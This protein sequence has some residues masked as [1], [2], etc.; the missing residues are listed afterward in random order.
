MYLYCPVQRAFIMMPNSSATSP[1]CPKK[2]DLQKW[3]IDISEKEYWG[4]RGRG[5]YKESP[6]S[7]RQLLM[8]NRAIKERIHCNHDCIQMGVQEKPKLPVD[9]FVIVVPVEIISQVGGIAQTLEHWIHIASISQITKASQSRSHPAKHRI[10]MADL[11]G[12]KPGNFCFWIA[13]RSVEGGK[14]S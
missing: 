8:G 11:W 9:I 5:I 4:K 1:L 14:K 13:H 12:W 6:T 2:L 10:Q 7:L 3:T